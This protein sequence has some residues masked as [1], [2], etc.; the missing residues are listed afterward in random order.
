MR[1]FSWAKTSI[2]KNLQRLKIDL[3]NCDWI[4]G[5]GEKREK[6]KKCDVT[7]ALFPDLT[8]CCYRV[9]LCEVLPKNKRPAAWLAWTLLLAGSRSRCL[10]QSKRRTDR[11]AEITWPQQVWTDSHHFLHFSCRCRVWGPRQTLD[12]F[13]L[14]SARGLLARTGT[15]SQ[16][17]V[18]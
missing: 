11:S 1:H 4:K 5:S 15:R 14:H 12:W 13:Y 18:W 9:F 8:L 6:R 16:Y 2:K 10:S 7:Q 17:C 3:M